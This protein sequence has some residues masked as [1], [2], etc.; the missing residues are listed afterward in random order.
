MQIGSFYD[1]T[2]IWDVSINNMTIEGG[3]VKGT[4][5]NTNGGIIFAQGGE[6]TLNLDTMILK[7]GKQMA[8]VVQ[9][10]QVEKQT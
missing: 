8:L 5:G 4:E 2:N 10:I 1:T 9:S 6:V 3:Y 7:G